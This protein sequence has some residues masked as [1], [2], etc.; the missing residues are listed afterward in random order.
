M[1]GLSPR[2]PGR[3]GD[4]GQLLLVGAVSLAVLLVALTVTLNAAMYAETL[5]TR[6]RGFGA[7][8]AVDFRD[9]VSEAA[10][11]ILVR[12]ND[13]GGDTYVELRSNFTR[14]VAD[15]SAAAG[16]LGALDGAGWNASVRD[17][18]RGTRVSQ[19]N[20]SR[21]FVDASGAPNWTVATDATAVRA[22]WLNVSRADLAGVAN[23]STAARLDAAGAFTVAFDGPDRRRVYVY[24]H[25][26]NGTVLVR[27]R[28]ASGDLGPR[29]RPDGSGAHVAV[30][31]TGGTVG[32]RAC[33]SLASLD[34]STPFD[35]SYVHGGGATG[36]YS[37]VV[38]RPVGTVT[39]DDYATGSGSPRA[40]PVLYAATVEVSYATSELR[41]VTT[42][43]VAPGE[44][45]A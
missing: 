7:T 27:V 32:G 12:T 42:L 38:D 26:A 17:T 29:C 43:R 18:T 19:S 45:D 15:W 6:E 22:F 9:A 33:P 8:S 30:D 41:Y 37:L 20:A 1:A 3:D 21:E 24:R 34:P 31:V 4:R 23:D 2:P 16:R 10:A 39:D 40:T 25:A 5:T 44:S 35:V 14:H 13:R 28:D 36:T 11:G